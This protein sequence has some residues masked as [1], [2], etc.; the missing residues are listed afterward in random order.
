[1]RPMQAALLAV[2]VL[3]PVWVFAG[4]HWWEP[5]W[6]A[7]L[8][9][10]LLVLRARHQVK[11]VL[12]SLAWPDWAAIVLLLG[13]ALAAALSNSELLLRLYPAGVNLGFFMVFFRSLYVPPTMIERFARVQTSVLS[14]EAVAYTRRVTQVWCGFFILNGALAVYTALATSRKVWALYNGG[15]AYALMGLLFG[16]EWWTRRRMM[17]REARESAA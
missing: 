8:V 15:I 11:T 1:M 16:A 17:A 4:L 3:T 2:S 6:V 7:G 10:L 9:L 5:R 13:L 14:P 12:G